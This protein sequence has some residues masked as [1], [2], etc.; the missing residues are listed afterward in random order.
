MQNNVDV[1][2]SAGIQLK[3]LYVEVMSQEGQRIIVQGEGMCER[4]LDG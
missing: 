1:V 2:V 3:H 4:P